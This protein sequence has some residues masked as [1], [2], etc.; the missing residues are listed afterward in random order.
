MSLRAG[1]LSTLD[2]PEALPLNVKFALANTLAQCL[3][4][5]RN[6]IV[7]RLVPLEYSPQEDGDSGPEQEMSNSGSANAATGS[8]A[9][10]VVATSKTSARQA[11]TVA[12]MESADTAFGSATAVT[13]GAT[14][15]A[16]AIA[17]QAHLHA[18]S[19]AP[20]ESTK[21]TTGPSM[22]V[23]VAMAGVAV[24]TPASLAAQT[25]TT[26]SID[27]TDAGLA[28]PGTCSGPTTAQAGSD[29]VLAAALR[30]ERPQPRPLNHCAS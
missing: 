6:A 29:A 16:V 12:P 25:D 8:V 23:A 24:A 1:Y 13:G 30:L 18:A 19:V 26:G 14:C 7:Y 3:E 27:S 4:P 21:N 28:I 11:A 15:V 20:M 22:H 10:I 5:L 17:T 2:W 9:G